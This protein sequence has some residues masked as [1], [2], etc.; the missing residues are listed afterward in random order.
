MWCRLATCGGLL[1]RGA[2]RQKQRRLAIGAQDAIL[3]H[4][5]S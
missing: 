2:Q 4:K 5:K 1:T 3:H